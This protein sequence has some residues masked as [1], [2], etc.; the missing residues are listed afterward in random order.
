MLSE[1]VFLRMAYEFN[2]M[3]QSDRRRVIYGQGNANN[4]NGNLFE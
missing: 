4:K 1:G 3:L 2:V